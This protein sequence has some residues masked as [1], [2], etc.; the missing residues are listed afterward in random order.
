MLRPLTTVVVGLGL[1]ASLKTFDIV[2]AMTQGGPGRNSETLAVTMYEETFVNSAYG[3]GSAVAVFLSAVTFL[4][5][6]T[7]LRR[8]LSTERTV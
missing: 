7:Y 8:Q 6:I 5:A 4:A 3:S 2:W 1:V